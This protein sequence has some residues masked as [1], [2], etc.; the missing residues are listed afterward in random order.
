MDELIPSMEKLLAPLMPVF[1]KEVFPTFCNMV[2]A[3]LVCLGRRTISRVWETT[4]KTRKKNHSAAFRLFSQAVWNFDEVMRVLLVAILQTFIPGM[5]VWVVIDDTLCHKR[6]GKV[7]FGGIFL[8]AVLSTRKHKT[9]RFGNNWVMLGLV[10]SMP[11]RRDRVFC[12]PLLW[13]V[14]EK[15]GKK[16]KKEHRT[17]PELA[18]D[19]VRTLATWLP[20]REI[21]VLGDNAY[22]CKAMLH[23][24]PENV[25]FIGPICWNA[26]LTKLKKQPDGREVSSDQRLPTPKEILKNDKEW[27]P[28]TRMI[29]FGDGK[30]RR[31]R[32]KVLHVCWKSVAGDCPVAIVLVQDPK[33]EWRDEALVSTNPNLSDYEI[34][35]G[36]CQRWSVEVAFGDAKAHLGFHDPC[37]WKK[38]SVER[39]APMSWFVGTLVMLWYAREGHNHEKAQRQRPWYVKKVITFTDM[40]STCRLAHWE[41][42]WRRRANK[43]P[44]DKAPFDWLLEYVATAE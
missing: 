19:M 35:T 25:N 16:T 2:V 1:R 36:Y 13:R 38:E 41:N 22:A 40:A 20:G 3:W 18:A 15:R 17:K 30:K 27:P 7:A 9:F 5:R 29:N 24:R 21:L 32:V 39:A 33:G 12:L 14:C 6:G 23:N 4:G 31:L 44:A 8:D 42:W 11:F 43:C 34:I 28:Q 10:V 37:V 26:A